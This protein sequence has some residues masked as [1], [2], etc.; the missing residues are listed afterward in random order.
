M[1]LGSCSNNLS[2]YL[3]LGIFEQYGDNLSYM[4]NPTTEMYLGIETD[5]ITS[6]QEAWSWIRAFTSSFVVMFRMVSCR[7]CFVIR[8]QHSQIISAI[9]A[10]RNED[11]VRLLES[12]V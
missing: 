4:Y 3:G 11:A 6:Y 9:E 5:T 10:E 8:K 1:K 12:S 2:L 7:F